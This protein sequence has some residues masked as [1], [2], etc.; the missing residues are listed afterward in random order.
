MFVRLLERMDESEEM[1][2]DG[3]RF[4]SAKWEQDAMHAA[5]GLFV[6]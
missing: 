4:F 6:P 3:A 2:W 1:E 5:C